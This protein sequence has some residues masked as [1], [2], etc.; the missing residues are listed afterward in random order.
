MTTI[1]IRSLTINLPRKSLKLT[2]PPSHLMQLLPPTHQRQKNLISLKKCIPLSH[3]PT[4]K[5]RR[6]VFKLIKSSVNEIDAKIT[7]RLNNR[8]KRNDRISPKKQEGRLLA[9][10]LRSAKTQGCHEIAEIETN[11]TQKARTVKI[12][13]NRKKLVNLVLLICQ[14][15]SKWMIFIRSLPKTHNPKRRRKNNRN[16]MQVLVVVQNRT[17]SSNFKRST[18]VLNLRVAL[19][20]LLSLISTQL[21]Q[22]WKLNVRLLKKLL[23]LWID[24]QCLKKRRKL[25]NQIIYSR[26]ALRK[27]IILKRILSRYS[28]KSL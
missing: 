11:Q 21:L 15:S 23:H 16:V 12:A 18:I 27:L 20:R 9:K 17:E 13:S 7:L 14:T 22:T 19:K 1:G 5:S 25:T 6:W 2:A 4:K 10:P 8:R 26:V 24:L 28:R 3:M